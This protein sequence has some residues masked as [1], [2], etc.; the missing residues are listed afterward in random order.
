MVSDINSIHLLSNSIT[1]SLYVSPH[2]AHS[3][4]V[5]NMASAPGQS[6][7]GYEYEFVKEAPEKFICSICTKVQRD[8][9]I[10]SCCGQHFCDFCLENWFK[11]QGKKSCPHCREEKDFNHFLD[12]AVKREINELKI[13][14]THHGKG[15]QWI[16]ELSNLQTHL[17]SE[18]GCGYVEVECPNRPCPNS[19]KRKDLTEHLNSECQ[20]RRYKCEHCG[21]E[22][23]YQGI[24]TYHYIRCPEYPLVCSY[25]CGA[26]VK[27]KD[28]SAH[29]EKCSEELVVCPNRCIGEPALEPSKSALKGPKGFHKSRRVKRKDLP[30]HLS[31]ECDQRRYRCEHCGHV[32]TYVYITGI[33]NTGKRKWKQAHCDTCHEYPLKCP[34]ECGAEPIKRKDMSTHRDKCPEEPMECPFKEAG[35]ET[36]LVRRD[37]DQHMTTQ[38]QQHMLLTFQKMQ[39][40]EQEL[41]KM[42]Y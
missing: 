18:S 34:N 2:N 37:F 40:L 41:R 27:R 35:C 6:Y 24:T 17:D 7:G 14:C 33:G 19:I 30:H 22:Y 4:T 3:I 39:A 20:Q 15:C 25:E 5:G 38:T 16:G 23:T 11:R 9:H 36:K 1:S 10:T 42:K 21:Y 32:D 31:N 28:M 8:P 29:R 12:K 26:K 13:H